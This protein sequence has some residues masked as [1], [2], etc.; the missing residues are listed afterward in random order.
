MLIEQFRVRNFKT[1]E[2]LSLK[3]LG[4]INILVGKND[5]GKSNIL[6]AL[7]MFFG[8]LAFPGG[9]GGA[10][11]TIWPDLN[12]SGQ[13][14]FETIVKVQKE[15][16]NLGTELQAR[17]DELF[18][19][20]M[21]VE[22]K[23][24]LNPK[25][26]QWNTSL[27][28]IDGMPIVENDSTTFEIIPRGGTTHKPDGGFIYS[29][30]LQLVSGLFGYLRGRLSWI[31]LDRRDSYQQEQ[32]QEFSGKRRP[33]VPNEILEFIFNLHQDLN[34]N[35]I[36][37]M[38]QL[39]EI[40][41]KFT[42]GNGLRQ[43]GRLLRVED[44]DF[45]PPIES[46]GY[47]KQQILI[48]SYNLLIGHQVLL[49]EEPESHFHPSLMRQAFRTLREYTES[50]D[51]QVFLTTHSSVFMNQA[52]FLDIWLVRRNE[53]NFTVCEPIVTRE[54]D[55]N[56]HLRVADEL[57][58]LPSDVGMTNTLLFVEGPSDEIYLSK[59]CQLI[60]HS[61]IHPIAQ[62]QIMGGRDKGKHKAE[63]WKSILAA[64]PQLKMGWLFDSDLP[65]RAFDDLKRALKPRGEVWRLELGT[66]EDYY[67]FKILKEVVLD[68]MEPSESQITAIEHLQSGNL[69]RK[70]DEAL[71][72]NYGW[73]VS[74]ARGVASRIKRTEDIPRNA[75]KIAED[76]AKFVFGNS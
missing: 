61:I 65:D 18:S 27:V 36:N 21:E 26:N 67:P 49:I 70:I 47:G 10:H 69:A 30:T 15:K 8:K 59:I 2:D 12:I 54:V 72:K 55:V 34:R 38:N 46:V 22:I 39:C 13:C 33:I 31:E 11:D 32:I 41:G 7:K 19:A 74:V 60:G 63:T 35:N 48:L 3:S 25:G 24:E 16:L 64:F 66:I 44:G 28:Q 37:R 56:E 17:I 42:G 6:D 20:E 57:G 75:R 76:I 14:E 53:Q 43:E 51:M 50:N 5:A 71:G 1:I 62:I 68:T 40:F 45:N 4:R 58:L 52:S 29:S 9:S 73:K 23:R